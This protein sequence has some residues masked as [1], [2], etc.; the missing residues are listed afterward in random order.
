MYRNEIEIP[1]LNKKDWT[2]DIEYI[3]HDTHKLVEGHCEAE[4]S[5]WIHFCFPCVYKKLGVT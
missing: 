4:W 1:D 2:K 3:S 5:I